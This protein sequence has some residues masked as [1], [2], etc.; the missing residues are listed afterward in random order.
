MPQLPA[1]H[2]LLSSAIMCRTICLRLH[3]LRQGS[4]LR[5]LVLLFLHERPPW[6]PLGRLIVDKLFYCFRL[7]TVGY[8]LLLSLTQVLLV[9]LQRPL[10][11]FQVL[12]KGV[13]E[14]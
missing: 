14:Q 5:H 13:P 7:K 12:P 3:L 11:A 1:C 6:V 4:L 2:N 10:V 8:P 9:T